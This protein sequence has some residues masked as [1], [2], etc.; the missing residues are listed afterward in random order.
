M[1][2]HL[3]LIL[4]GIQISTISFAQKKV[5]EHKVYDD[6]RTIKNDQISR[7]GEFVSFE[8]MSNGE[9]DPIVNVVGSTGNKLLTYNRGEKPQITFDS[10]HVIF[11]IKPSLD[12][13][14]ALRRKKIKEEDLP[15][16]S[17]AVF[18][19]DSKKVSKLPGLLDLKVPKKWSGWVA[20]RFE[21]D[22][23]EEKGDS[24]TLAIYNLESS[25]IFKYPKVLT[26][27]LSEE[28]GQIAFESEGDST[29]TP[30]VYV[31]DTKSTTLKP[32][33][34]SKGKY[35]SLT[36]DKAGSQ[37]A[38]ITD[39]DSTKSLLRQYDLHLW[40]GADSSRRV[41]HSEL[42]VF[43]N[44]WQVSEKF[45]ELLFEGWFQIILRS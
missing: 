2:I 9:S 32:V 38:F 15:G 4:L 3:I 44:D 11:S 12:S 10:R 1:R 34:R 18:T 25:E 36:W 37:L 39:L 7:N 43:E 6:W 17:L 40:E 31:F 41:A 19:V 27:T 26:Y 35:F 30:G 23:M 24:R 28:G 16:D 8:L 45:S 20:Y 42:A 5:L 14:K 21:I 13:L 29:F 33:F 22:S